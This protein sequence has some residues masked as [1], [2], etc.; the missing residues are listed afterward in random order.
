MIFS[1]RWTKHD[2]FLEHVKQIA[3]IVTK[4]KPNLQP[5]IWDDMLRRMDRIKLLDS[6]IGNYAHPMV[7]YYGANNFPAVWD[8]YDGV[9]DH[10]WCASAFKG[11]SGSAQIIP[12]LNLHVENQK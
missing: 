8:L 9:F 7:W 2:L 6:Q 3:Q 4:M 5:I 10:F 11:A 1:F 12:D